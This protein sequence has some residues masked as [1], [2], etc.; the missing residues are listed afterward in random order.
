M[1]LSKRGEYGLR[2]MIDLASWSGDRKTIQLKEIADRENI[3][4]KFL[5]QIML[6]LKNAGLVNSKMGV[7]GGYYLSQPVESISLGQ[8]IRILDGPLAPIRCVSQTAYEP[9]NCPE[10]NS[11]GLRKVMFRVRNAIADILDNQTLA[12]VVHNQQQAN[13]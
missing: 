3:P 11:C 6:S 10:E 9:C 13:P 8:I 4:I 7:N 2:A 1:R 12:E 5:E